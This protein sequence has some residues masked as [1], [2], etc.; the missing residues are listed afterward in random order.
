MR[1]YFYG[2]QFRVEHDSAKSW[3][4]RCAAMLNVLLAA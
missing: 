3:N 1:I 4:Y 2:T